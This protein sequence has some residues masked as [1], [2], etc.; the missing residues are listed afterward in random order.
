MNKSTAAAELR[1]QAEERLLAKR[2][3]FHHPRTEEETQ[4]LVHELEVHQI[5]LEMQDTVL[6]QTRDDLEKALVQLEAVLNSINEGVVI[7]DL[8]GNILTMNSSALAFHEYASVEQVRQQLHQLQDTFELSDL[9][10]RSVPFEQWPLS[11]VLRGEQLTDLELR[12]RRK[13]KGT[14]RVGSYSGTPVQTGSGDII[15]AVITVRNITEH[16]RAEEQIEKLN[17]DLAAHAVEL[18]D[19]NRELETFNYTVAHDLRNPLNVISGYCQVIKELCNDKL[20]EQC[21]NYL[22]EVYNGTLRMNRLIE[23]LLQFSRLAHAEMKRD[24]VD[25]SSMARQIAVELK[26]TGPD[27]L[28][29]FRV[30]DGISA[31]GDPNLLHVVLTNLF[32]NAWK[33]T[34]KREETIIEFAVTE[35]DGRPVFSI[36]DNGNGFDM[37]DAAKLFIPFQRLP[38]VEE[39]RGFGIGLATVERII[40]RHGGRVW[41][42]GAIGKGATFYFTLQS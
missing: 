21:K 15:L 42:E 6:R 25:L 38:G 40:R 20:D 12:V 32:D 5:E 41:A 18:E 30:A 17:I 9:K 2:A 10:G 31:V 11:R 26:L 13:D 7:A 29:N 36:R 22:Q 35:R 27:R 8:S 14:S 28:V 24:R 3:G 19:A 39:C 37:T 4:R 1:R 23:A 16:K 33:Y 34:A